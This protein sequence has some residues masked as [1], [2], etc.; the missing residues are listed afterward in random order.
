MSEIVKSLM[1]DIKSAMKE[2]NKEALSVLRMLHSDIKNIGIDKGLEVTDELALDVVIK[3]I[4]QKK[5]SIE[6]FG[7]GGRQDLVEK[8]EAGMVFLE[9]FLPKALSEE[10][11]KQMIA[12]AVKELEVSGPQA[13][14]VLM[15]TLSPKLKGK[16]D[17]KSLSGWIKEAIS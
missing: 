8:E 12:E 15:K 6:Q 3:T 17:N 9:K 16:V 2:K 14:G 7:N 5:D 10:E 1:G 11:V 13:M 4:K